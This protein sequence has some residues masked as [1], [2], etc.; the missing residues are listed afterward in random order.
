MNDDIE[1][2]SIP[3]FADRLGVTASK[4]RDK[5]HD[6]AVVAVRR[7]PNHAWSLPEVFI[8]I[9]DGGPHIIASLRGT[10]T[11]LADAGFTDDDAVEWMLTPHEEL[12][13]TPVEQLRQGHKAHVRRLAQ[14]LL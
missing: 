13:T 12:G 10:F 7:G 1:W 5:M 2:L 4:V 11:L 6:R 9:G 3:E 8:A 14:A